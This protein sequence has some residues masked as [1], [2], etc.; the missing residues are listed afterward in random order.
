M[1]VDE[2]IIA[3]LPTTIETAGMVITSLVA[4]YTAV[5]AIKNNAKEN[6]KK[7]KRINS[8]ENQLRLLTEDPFSLTN[9]GFYVD[10]DGRRYCGAGCR[11]ETTGQRVPL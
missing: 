4:A 7:A 6:D 3:I 10:N 1:A 11:Q 2:I 8:L 5:K 9:E